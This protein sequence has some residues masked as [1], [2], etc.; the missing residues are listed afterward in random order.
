MAQLIYGDRIGAQ[1]PLIVSTAAAIFDP[2]GQKV[3]LTRRSDNGQWCLP[4]GQ[5]EPGES[6]AEGCAREA[7][8]ETGLTVRITRL[9]GVYS[10]PHMLVSYPDGNRYQIVALTFA[11]EVAAGQ[12]AVSNETTAWGWYAPAEFDALDIMA[13]HRLRL[14]DVFAGQPEAFIR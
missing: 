4:G 13:H 12:P 9:I 8:E 1:A 5:L 3:L 14:A 6:A 7:L 2:S 10:S 11:A